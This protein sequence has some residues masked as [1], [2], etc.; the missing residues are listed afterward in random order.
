LR[1]RWNVDG[2][3]RHHLIDPAT[4]EPSDSDLELTTVIAGEAWI[5]EVLAKAVLLRGSVRAFDIVD[6]SQVQALTI[7]TAGVIRTTSRFQE[8]AGAI[9]LPRTLPRQ[10]TEERP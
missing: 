8:F 1:R 7:D 3:T 5:A 6:D 2:Q 9:P 10:R 4:G